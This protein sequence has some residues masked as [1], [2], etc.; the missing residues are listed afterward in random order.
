VANGEKIDEAYVQINPDV[1][2]FARDVNRELTVAFR[3]VEHKLDDV[4]DSIDRSFDNLARQ[5]DVLFDNLSYEMRQSLD[6]V[7]DRADDTARSIALDISAGANSAERSVDDLAD[8]ATHD[9]RRIQREARSTGRTLALSMMGG[10]AGGAISQ[11]AEIGGTLRNLGAIPLSLG[12][13]L[14]GALKVTAIAALVPIIIA[15]TG[16]LLDLI[17]LLLTL[18]AAFGVLAAIIAPLPI[19]FQ[20]V[21]DAIK[22]LVSGDLEKLNEAMKKLTPSA[23]AFVMEFDKIRKPMSDL[24]KSVQ[25]AFFGQIGGVL[26]K[27]ATF[28]LPVLRDG[29]AKVATILGIVVRLFG[30]MLSSNDIL[31]AFRNILA[32]AARVL[33]ILGP[34]IVDAFGTLIGTVEGGLPFIERF[35]FWLADVL[36]SFGEWQ[37]KARSSGQFMGWIEV[38]IQTLKDLGTLTKSVFNLIGAL[39]GDAGDEG[40]G[41]ILSVADALNQLADFLRTTEGKQFLQ[42]ILDSLKAVAAFLIYVVKV[43]ASAARAWNDFNDGIARVIIALVSVWNWLKRVGSSIVSFAQSIGTWITN[44]WSKIT[45]FFTVTIPGMIS[46]AAAFLLRVPGMLRD[47]AVQA[48][49]NMFFAIGFG[50]GTMIK[51]LMT[52]PERLKTLFMTIWNGTIEVTRNAVNTIINFFT[53]TL[54]SRLIAGATMIWGIVTSLFH[55]GVNNATS[56]VNTLPGRIWDALTNAA[57]RARAA[58]LNILSAAYD[59]GRNMIQGMI[60]GIEAGVGRLIDAAKR[61]VQRALEGARRALGIAS[62]SKEWAKLGAMSVAGY[63]RGVDRSIGV[64]SADIGNA[65]RAPMTSS[66]TNVSN[67]HAE[68]GAQEIVVL[69]MLDGEVI[70]R[71]I[72][73]TMKDNP[74]EVATAAETGTTRLS[75]RR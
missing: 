4:V 66:T 24:R 31:I 40:R 57:A 41:F 10:A 30:E 39:A 69:L 71:K 38:A 3:Q 26:T 34:A 14:L 58:A 55:Q 60:N 53:T 54:P 21:G 61:A 36:R 67:T 75:R 37:A 11:L 17:P 49:D 9:L 68:T 33:E 74:Q 73:R 35:A 42:S 64:S 65:I 23:R 32:S 20:G 45:T 6:D 28:L 2:N 1:D 15:L 19:A 51:N 50:I 63:S 62:P 72:I 27:L 13:G 59:I 12:G 48:F 5:L 18:P 52:L 47:M 44:V 46:S 7:A 8:E 56:A 43:I 70:E 22:A 29:L 25:E 16:A